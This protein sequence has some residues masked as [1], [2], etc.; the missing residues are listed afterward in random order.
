MSATTTNNTNVSTGNAYFDLKEYISSIKAVDVAAQMASSVAFTVDLA[1]AGT[2]RQIMKNVRA[3]HDAYGYDSVG[4]MTDALR[5]FE[6][7][8]QVFR[9]H[10][11]A[12]AGLL[13]TF[14]NLLAIREG[15][16]DLASMLTGMTFNWDGTPRT[17]KYITFEEFLSRE[18]DIKV[19]PAVER[20]IRVTVQRR[21]DG[22][23]KE[24]IDTVIQ[25]RMQREQDKAKDV[26]RVLTEQSAT[27]LTMYDLLA[28]KAYELAGLDAYA[29]EFEFYQLG[30][31][32]REQLIN[33]ALKG[34]ARAEEYATSSR[35]IT[36]D[37]FDQISFAV[38]KVE[39]ELK[40]V[41]TG[42]AYRMTS[43]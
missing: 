14:G 38:I 27:L 17:Y 19:Q 42:S 36:D 1:M 16:H 29:E 40:A 35:S 31:K 13:E 41:L 33:A 23:S 7:T 4:A 30:A 12:E 20:R 22:A 15:W 2:L 28:D 9:E 21:A 34:A 11:K 3:H 39:R 6:F 25:R 8:E 37:E 32:L 24:D 26:S 5:D 18:V 43:I 10:G